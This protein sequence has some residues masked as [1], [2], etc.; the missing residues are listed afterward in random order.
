MELTE[1][2]F[3]QKYAKYCLQCSRNT[4]LPYEYEWTCIAR[5]Y[6]LMNRKQEL[7]KNQRK[8]INSINRLQHAK[9]KIFCICIEVYPLYEGVDYV[10][11]YEILSTLKNKK[12]KKNK[13]LIG[14]YKDML[15]NPSFEQDCYS[16]TVE[17]I[18]KIG[19]DSIRV[20][21]WLAY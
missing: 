12:S 1:D 18:Y 4:L 14:K 6:N 8:K 10:K 19:H 11:M 2:D 21:K 7:S 20:M 9:Q 5:R 16:R 13:I 15:E 17:C 3:I